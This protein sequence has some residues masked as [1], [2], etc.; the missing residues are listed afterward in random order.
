[1]QS[2]RKL[3]PVDPRGASP[4]WRWFHVLNQKVPT[5]SG[6]PAD[7]P[8]LG[9]GNDLIGILEGATVVRSGPCIRSTAWK[10]EHR[11][12]SIQGTKNTRIINQQCSAVCL[13]ILPRHLLGKYNVRGV[14]RCTRQDSAALYLIA[15]Y[16]PMIHGGDPDLLVG[17]SR[18]RRF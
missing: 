18:D 1:M 17:I 6:S 14:S 15:V 3:N 9:N 5:C 10:R 2:L 4:T 8:C 12:S 7:P 11:A 13:G 16:A